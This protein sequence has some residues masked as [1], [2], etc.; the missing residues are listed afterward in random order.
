MIVKKLIFIGPLSLPIFGA[1]WLYSC[2]GRYTRSQ[3]HI[4]NEDKYARYG[5]VVREEG[6]MNFPLIHLY[7]KDDI[8]TVLKFRSD[9]PM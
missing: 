3:Y 4:S 1:L 5:P 7:H 2:F 6:F 8:S 9:M